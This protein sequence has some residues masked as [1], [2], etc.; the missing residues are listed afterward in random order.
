MKRLLAATLVLGLAACASAPKKPDTGA[1]AVA[2]KAADATTPQAGRKSPY[3]PAQEDPGKRGHYTA[4]GLYA[5][6][7]ADSTPDID[8]DVSLIPE[9][10]VVAEPRSAYG[11]RPTYAVL[12]KNYRVLD[13]ARGYVEKGTASYY[14]NKFHGRR[15]SNM[16]VYD[17]YAFTAAHKS[18][19]LP[20][21]ARVTN[22]DNG[23]SVVVR[24]NDRGP[25]HEG[26]VIDLSY[27]AALKLGITRA[28]TGRVEVRALQPGEDDAGRAGKRDR[29][30]AARAVA[31]VAPKPAP[32]S[33]MDTLV[34]ALPKGATG[35]G[36]LSLPP[37]VRIATGKPTRLDRAGASAA[38]DTMPATAPS[39]PAPAPA[40]ADESWRF[41]MNQDGRTMTADEFDAWME[42]RKVRVATGRDGRPAASTA[43]VAAGT[44]PAVQVVTSTSTSQA[45]NVT[46]Q[47][48]SFAARDNADRALAILR[49]AG[50]DR[51]RLHDAT[52]NGQR[53]WRLRVGPLEATTA[54]GL[55]NRIAGLG[56]G[57][58]QRVNE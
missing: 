4:G 22:L 55:A 8:I 47:V 26:R 51:A 12:G 21:F 33:S 32:P 40:T 13:D 52:A 9:P 54:N 43:R 38:A 37:G 44:A 20:S 3:P 45:D 10:E 15:T 2:G 48:A 36:A 53:V 57:A 42:Q 35:A 46:L 6:H 41:D 23:E 19:P 1:K 28:G 49:G 5:P 14:G 16:E 18:L 24:V 27:A 25:F 7:I 58:P 29:E 31:A 56:F 17:M 30:D 39:S 50:I 11:N 34:A